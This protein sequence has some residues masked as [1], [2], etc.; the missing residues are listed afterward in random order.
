MQEILLDKVTN[1][2]KRVVP[3]AAIPFDNSVNPMYCME[4][5]DEAMEHD[6]EL[7]AEAEDDEQWW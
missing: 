4:Y 3:E 5:K 7:D 2:G 1:E 6:P